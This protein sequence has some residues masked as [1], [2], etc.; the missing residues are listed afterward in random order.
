MKV[1]EEIRIFITSGSA[2]FSCPKCDKARTADVS[3]I[4][5]KK[6]IIKINCKCKCGY[7]FKAVLE[8]RK[9][10][11]KNIKLKGTCQLESDM[12]P[13]VVSVVDLSR[14]GCKIK[15]ES[16]NNTFLENDKIFI[17]FNLD[18]TN[19]SL[20]TKSAIIKSSQGGIIGAEFES[21][22]EYDKI[23]QYLMFN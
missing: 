10:F 14:S 22:N 2:T 3:K 6:A 5:A 20:I 21:M 9:F 8:R 23:G 11:R 1:L 17:E 12:R 18:D 13:I 15:L 4:I 19:N 16:E 7:T